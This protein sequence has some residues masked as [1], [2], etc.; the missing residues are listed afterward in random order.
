M[1]FNPQ[2]VIGNMHD[3]CDN[4]NRAIDRVLNSWVDRVSASM[5]ASCVAQLINEGQEAVNT[6]ETHSRNI[7]NLLDEMEMFARR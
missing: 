4:Y 6:M 3:Q 1:F 7:L 2:S 5:Q